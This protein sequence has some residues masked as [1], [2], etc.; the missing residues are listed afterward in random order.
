MRV[1]PVVAGA[2]FVLTSTVTLTPGV[3]LVGEPVG[4]PVPKNT[5]GGARIL[6]RITTPRAPL[7]AITEGCGLKGLFI[8]YDRMPF[9][10]DADFTTSGEFSN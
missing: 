5:T 9:P 8:L 4:F 7:F 2:G 10:A 6:A 1:P 3:K